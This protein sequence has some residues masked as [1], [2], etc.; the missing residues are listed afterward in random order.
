MVICIWRKS[1]NCFKIIHLFSVIFFNC[2]LGNDKMIKSILCW[3]GEVCEFYCL[4]AN[5]CQEVAW[6]KLRR[7]RT[8]HSW[9]L[10]FQHNSFSHDWCQTNQR[11]LQKC[12]SFFSL[13]F[14][15]S[16][17]GLHFLS[18]SWLILDYHSLSESKVD[19]LVVVHI[20]FFP[21]YSK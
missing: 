4:F 13:S 12:L 21:R 19:F 18:E 16:T 2:L 3:F 8:V 5:D 9:H 1:Y 14:Y 7:T 11:Y 17:I 15:C 6:T 20:N 10:G